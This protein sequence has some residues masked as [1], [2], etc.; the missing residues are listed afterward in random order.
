MDLYGYCQIEDLE[1]LL[2]L[3]GIEDIKRLRGLRL[4]AIEEPIDINKNVMKHAVTEAMESLAYEYSCRCNSRY[5]GTCDLEDIFKGIYCYGD[6]T[7]R[8]D[9]LHG[10][11]RKAAKFEIKKTKKKMLAQYEMFNKYVGREDVLY[12]HTRT[13]GNNWNYYGCFEY[14]NKPWYLDHVD[15]YWD[16]TYCDIYAKIDPAITNSLLK[17]SMESLSKNINNVEGKDTSETT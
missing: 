9:R 14:L 16:S 15:D 8:W 4:M 5:F 10:K 3:N 1:P 11:L 7:P 12:I 2:I 6:G 17:E 13:G